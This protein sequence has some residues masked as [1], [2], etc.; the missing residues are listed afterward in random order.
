M[1]KIKKTKILTLT[2][3]LAG[4]MSTSLMADELCPQMAF[5]TADNELTEFG[6]KLTSKQ[7]LSFCDNYYFSLIVPDDKRFLESRAQEI[8]TIASAL[9]QQGAIFEIEYSDK[10][11]ELTLL[12]GESIVYE[13]YKSATLKALVQKIAEKEGYN[14][15]W[16]MSK[17]LKFAVDTSYRCQ[18]GDVKACVTKISEDLILNGVTAKFTLYLGNK[19]IVITDV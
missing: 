13:V 3:L 15:V 11:N 10:Y 14:V 17:D 1:L 4:V 19:T 18:I 6:R 12:R 5:L 7:S 2:T 16:K 8:N 9:K